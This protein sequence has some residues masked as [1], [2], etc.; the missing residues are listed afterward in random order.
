MNNIISGFCRNGTFEFT[1]G[2]RFTLHKK[3]SIA[4][5]GRLYNAAQIKAELNA[6]CSGDAQVLLNAYVQWG[7]DFVNK[8]NG[9]FAFAIHDSHA[10]KLYL[11][12]DHAG[13]KPLLYAIRGDTLVF[14]SDYDTL[15][16]LDYITPEIDL[17]SLR[18]V[19][20]IGPA[21]KP[22]SGVFKGVHQLRPA[23]CG[24]F[25]GGKLTAK[26][27]R[28]LTSRPHTDNYEQTVET[29]YNLV[30]DAVHIR[31]A[32]SRRLCSMLSG[33]VDSSIVTAVA[34][35]YLSER[36]DTI[37][38][39][40]LDFAGNDQHFAAN[41]FQPERDRPFVDEMLRKYPLNHTYTECGQEALADLLHAATDA[42]GVPGMA[43][44][45]TSLLYFCGV[46]NPHGDAV[47]TGECADETGCIRWGSQVGVTLVGGIDGIISIHHFKLSSLS[48]ST[49]SV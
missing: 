6:E 10:Q 39:F 9:A 31:V 35:R 48:N 11:F 14:A 24:V 25:E 49:F 12:R 47:L 22:D 19:F 34:S 1:Q 4:Y 46:I 17:Q 27:Y 15:F 29:V 37:N 33:G 40:S 32:N 8:L 21:R 28:T 20:G 41:D 42:R 18:E 2:E 5:T 23:H 45:D 38:T 44:I 16:K 7:A 13:I 3:F 26:R 43:D 36:G 30:T